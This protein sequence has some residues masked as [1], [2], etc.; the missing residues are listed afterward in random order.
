V[1][2]VSLRANRLFRYLNFVFMNVKQIGWGFMKSD[3]GK[4]YKKKLS[5]YLNLSL[6]EST[7]HL[8]TTESDFRN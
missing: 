4:F 3:V 2:C 1:R 7:K 5:K 8:K 6:L